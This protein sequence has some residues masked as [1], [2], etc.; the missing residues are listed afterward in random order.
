MERYLQDVANSRGDEAV[1]TL[2][3][4]PEDVRTAFGEEAAVAQ[5]TRDWMLQ[6]PGFNTRRAPIR[7]WL[8]GHQSEYDAAELAIAAWRKE[9]EAEHRAWMREQLFRDR[10]DLD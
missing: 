6:H 7:N 2:R 10:Y 3:F 4:T 5:K 8:I 1:P 9:Q